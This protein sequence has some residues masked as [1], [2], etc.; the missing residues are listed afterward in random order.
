MTIFLDSTALLARYVDGTDRDLITEEMSLDSTWCASAMALTEVTMVV[1][2]MDLS[3]SRAAS[4]R[5]SIR[6]EWDCFNVIPVDQLCLDRAVAIGRTQ[7]VR[8]IEAIHLAAADRLP[9]T[10]SYATFDS[11]QIGPALALGFRV[12]SAIVPSAGSARL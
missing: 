12:V 2:R 8:A 9:P 10:I 11:N 5:A 4:L 7:P 6:R 1:D 3:R